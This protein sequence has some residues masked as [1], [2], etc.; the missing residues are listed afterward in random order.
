MSRLV[1]IEDTPRYQTAVFAA[2]AETD[3]SIVRTAWDLPQAHQALTDLALGELEADYLL[4]DGNLGARA[5]ENLEFRFTPP[6]K[7]L[8]PIV[9]PVLYV[10]TRAPLRKGWR[11]VAD[12]AVDK[13]LDKAAELIKP[14]APAST[15]P[16]TPR[17]NP[18]EV[19]VGYK[20]EGP[21]IQADGR[22]VCRI[23][24]ALGLDVEI[25]GISGDEAS[26]W[27]G[28][29]DY[30]LTKMRVSELASFLDEIE[31]SKA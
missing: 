31:A 5:S 4:V 26:H 22:Q 29:V 18:N 20:S 9:E 21:Q 27:G 17:F 3:H 14:T 24:R 11:G 7:E 10:P 13:A 2:V 15:L 12:W 25:I 28:D 1:V 6:G 16:P 30:D 8:P 23:V 19:V